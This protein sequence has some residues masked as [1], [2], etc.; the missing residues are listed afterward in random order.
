[1][2]QGSNRNIYFKKNRNNKAEID[3]NGINNL[4]KNEDEMFNYK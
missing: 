2:L 1:M 3:T 4:K